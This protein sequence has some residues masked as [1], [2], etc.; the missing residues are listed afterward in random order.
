[1]LDV[2]MTDLELRTIAS[3][4]GWERVLKELLNNASIERYELGS[5]KGIL[6]QNCG[7]YNYIIT[8][9]N[10]EKWAVRQRFGK[11]HL[12]P[13]LCKLI[14]EDNNTK[15]KSRDLYKLGSQVLTVNLKKLMYPYSKI[16]DYTDL[17]TFFAICTE[18]HRWKV[19]NCSCGTRN[20][21]RCTCG[22]NDKRDKEVYTF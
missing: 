13:V 22:W 21:L 15:D 9:D 12:K 16:T 6:F 4:E 17:E 20:S 14:P 3:D 5:P 8:L 11:D 1:M 19:H 10:G 7:K 18:L 2:D